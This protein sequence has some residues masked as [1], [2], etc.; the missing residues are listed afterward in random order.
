MA[1][2]LHFPTRRRLSHVPIRGELVWNFVS[3][4]RLVVPPHPHYESRSLGRYLHSARLLV[5]IVR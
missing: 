5:P 1:N 4:A 2:L 3:G